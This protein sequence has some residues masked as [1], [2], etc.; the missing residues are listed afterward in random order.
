MFSMSRA[1]WCFDDFFE[2]VGSD[3]DI[4]L[5][6]SRAIYFGRVEWR[7]QM[8]GNEIPGEIRKR[9]TWLQPQGLGF[10]KKNER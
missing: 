4:F 2:G 5:S 8:K 7:A 3:S 6:L 1:R 10:D 9:H